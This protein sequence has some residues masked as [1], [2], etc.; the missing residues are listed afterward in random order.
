[1]L[2]SKHCVSLCEK[3]KA[4]AAESWLWYAHKRFRVFILT[5]EEEEEA[6]K[7]CS[8]RFWYVAT[9]VLKLR[10]HY[11]DET[12]PL[13]QKVHSVLQESV[14]FKYIYFTLS[15]F[16]SKCCVSEPLT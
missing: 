12:S 14:E 4:A 5:E 13:R 1:M 8:C 6:V 16:N 3:E 15:Y 11:S 2:G 9:A 10:P 7:C